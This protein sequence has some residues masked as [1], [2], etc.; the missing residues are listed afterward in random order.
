MV[1]VGEGAVKPERC[2]FVGLSG[3]VLVGLR[4]ELDGSEKFLMGLW[5]VW[6]ESFWN[7]W[8]CLWYSSSDWSRNGSVK[9]LKSR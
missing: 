5:G 6:R 8:S 2:D 7:C 3:P 9:G 4:G 1:E